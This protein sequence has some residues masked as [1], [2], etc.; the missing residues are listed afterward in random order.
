MT[1]D[2]GP[3]L[4]ELF[5]LVDIQPIEPVNFLLTDTETTNTKVRLLSTTAKY[6]NIVAVT[7]HE[8][9]RFG[10]KDLWSRS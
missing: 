9:V 10:R 5:A 2:D 1:D 3:S 7:E 4:A 8:S 6:F